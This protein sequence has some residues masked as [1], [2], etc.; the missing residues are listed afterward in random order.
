MRLASTLIVL[1]LG[2]LLTAAAAQAQ[3]SLTQNGYTIHYSAIPTLDLA[4][5]VARGYVITRSAN[6]ALL[7][8]AVRQGEG[9]DSRALVANIQGSASNDAGQS[10]M[11]S[12]RE[13]REG[14]A[15]YYLAEP[16]M[17][18]GDTLRFD[19][20]VTPE[21]SSSPIRVRFSRSFYR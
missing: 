6:R 2:C 13:I 7:N 19:L 10:Q 3:G 16:R 14:E 17:R 20:L 11:L 5:E 8:I 9:S 4:P 18:P 1:L 15:I 12:L 21:G